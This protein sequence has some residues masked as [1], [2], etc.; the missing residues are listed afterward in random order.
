[1]AGL[2]SDLLGELTVSP[3]HSPLAELK[4]RRGTKKEGGRG[5]RRKEG[6]GPPND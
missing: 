3:L 2:H 5:K 6:E 4:G 1:V